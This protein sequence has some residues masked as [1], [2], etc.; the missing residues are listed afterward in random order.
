MFPWFIS[1]WEAARISLEA[2]C[3]LAFPFFGFISGQE[4]RKKSASAGARRANQTA[5]GSLDSQMSAGPMAAGLP[6]MAPVSQATAKTAPTRQAT[7][8]I[9]ESIGIKAPKNTKGGTSRT[10][11][12]DRPSRTK[13]K[14]RQK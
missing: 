1:P 8:G 3:L 2:Q 6:K 14:R 9:V 4:R 13:H 10:K 7:G 12:K 5:A 11:Q